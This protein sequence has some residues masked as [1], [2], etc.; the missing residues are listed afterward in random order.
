M[1]RY[2]GKVVM[3]VG[4][5]QGI[6]E[7]IARAYGAE[8]A[9]LAMFDIQEKIHETGAA[10]KAEAGVEDLI[11]GIVDITSFEACQNAVTETVDAF[12]RIDVLALAS[13]TLTLGSV[14]EMSV[15]VWNKVM[16]VNINGYFYM[17]KAVIPQMK[18]QKSGNMVLTGSWSAYAGT[19][20]FSAYCC[21]KAAVI[22]LMHA[23]AEELAG[24]GIRVN[25]VCP[26]SIATSLHFNC[27]EEQAE[28]AGITVEEQKKI[29]YSR[30]AMHRPGQPSE[31]ADAFVFLGTDQA[32][33]ITGACIDVN[34]GGCL[35]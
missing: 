34:G 20:Y 35:R 18:A 12:G 28:A 25:C 6:G 31:I 17:T 7:A 27:L 10:V 9:K 2:E 26:G 29:D 11:T 21:S 15:E 13:G 30:M 32:S 8:G 24:D 3:V 5:A 1:R 22:R 19:A 4:C 14:E 23:L 16:D 33:Y